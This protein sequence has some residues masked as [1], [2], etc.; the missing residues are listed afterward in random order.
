MDTR[1]VDRSGDQRPTTM[2]STEMVKVLDSKF[3]LLGDKLTENISKKITD[4]VSERINALEKALTESA[5]FATE[6]A[7][8][9]LKLAKESRSVINGLTEQVEFL[10][11][12]IYKIE[13]QTNNVQTHVN[14]NEMYSRKAN[15]IFTCYDQPTVDCDVLV[16]RIFNVMKHSQIS[17]EVA[18][19]L[20]DNKQLIVKFKSVFDRNIIWNARKTLKGSG[21]YANEDLPAQIQ[22]EHKQLV[23]IAKA[24]RAMPELPDR[25]YVNA[26]KL[27]MDGQ[28]YSLETLP[29]AIQP[30]R[31]SERKSET[32]LCFGGLLSRHHP[33][34]N[35]CPAS[36][37]VNNVS[38]SSSE[39]AFQHAKALQFGD[40]R[41]AQR[42]M[43]NNDPDEHKR[44]GRNIANYVQSEWNS[45]R[46][47]ILQVILR[48]KFTQNKNHREHL[49]NSGTR[50]LAEA[51]ARD[52]YYGIG[53]PI[54]HEDILDENAWNGENRLGKLLMNLRTTMN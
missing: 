29:E 21:Y 53:L 1:N 26:N 16:K 14:R 37:K 2:N 18:H 38:Y 43:N 23:I 51:S 52:R 39:Q 32:V 30:K 8:E 46:D 12:Y 20:R 15:L 33:L 48:A 41:S 17:Y 44:I 19:F 22:R 47:D 7:T 36:F 13:H 4:N 34:S 42:I 10:K 54:T 6:T 25:V 49:M 50:K 27:S 24:A 9:A 28:T 45:V 11:S 5:Q 35:F 40:H 3:E 31:I